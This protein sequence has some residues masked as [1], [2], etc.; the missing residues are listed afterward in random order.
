MRPDRYWFCVAVRQNLEHNRYFDPF[1]L[2]RAL[3]YGID[4]LW[5]LSSAAE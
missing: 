5:R 4:C 2:P 1:H 3:I